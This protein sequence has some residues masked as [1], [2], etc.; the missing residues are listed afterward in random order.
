MRRLLKD[1]WRSQLKL[2]QSYDAQ[3]VNAT[4]ALTPT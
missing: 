3:R 4:L 1:A 2:G